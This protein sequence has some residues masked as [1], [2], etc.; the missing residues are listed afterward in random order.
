[1][2]LNCMIGRLNAQM[3]IGKI[4]GVR[5][6]DAVPLSLSISHSLSEYREKE[7]E[8]ERHTQRM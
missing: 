2:G 3:L 1:M 5:D 8:R 4:F 6:R 7:E